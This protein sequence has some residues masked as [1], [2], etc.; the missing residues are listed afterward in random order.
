MVE[1]L[2]R[3]DLEIQ[4][5]PPNVSTISPPY[6]MANGTYKR[7]FKIITAGDN[8]IWSADADNVMVMIYRCLHRN[9]SMQGGPA[10]SRQPREHYFRRKYD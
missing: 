1:K 5:T 6:I 3:S 8:L 2:S 4:C 9:C 7:F 10:R